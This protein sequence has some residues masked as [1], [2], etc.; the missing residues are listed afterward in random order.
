[1]IS[2]LFDG[3]MFYKEDGVITVDRVGIDK[4]MIDG[5]WYEK[6]QVEETVKGLKNSY[7]EAENVDNTSIQSLVYKLL[8]NAERRYRETFCDIERLHGECEVDCAVFGGVTEED[9]SYSFTVNKRTLRVFPRGIAEGAVKNV[10]LPAIKEVYVIFRDTQDC[11]G[12][13]KSEILCCVADETMAQQIVTK[14][15]EEAQF[16]EDVQGY[17]YRKCPAVK[18]VAEITKTG[19]YWIFVSVDCAQRQAQ[20]DHMP[21]LIWTSLSVKNEDDYPVTG[22]IVDDT[23]WYTTVQFRVRASQLKDEGFSLRK[24]A[25]TFIR[26]IKGIQR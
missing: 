15:N 17:C 11:C 21:S 9:G 10:G 13:I 2:V 12:D 4:V 7:Y 22:K 24:V 14:K 18:S 23:E 1:M 5:C 16:E 8:L 25:N 26:Q 3:Q 20:S 19:D 6:D